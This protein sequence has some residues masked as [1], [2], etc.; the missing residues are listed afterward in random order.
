VTVA[1]GATSSAVTVSVNPENGFT[2]TVQVSLTGVPVGVTSNP[3]SPFSIAAGSGTPVIF[4]A[5]ANAVTGT[6]TVSAQGSSGSLSHSANLSLIVQP[7]IVAALPRTAFVRTDSVGLVDNPQ[8]EAR[9]RH[10]VYDAARKQLFVANRAMNRVEVLSS[11]DLARKTQIAVPAASS[12]DLSADGS[13]LWV[14]TVTNQAVAIDPQ[15]L[16]IRTRF[17][18][19]MLAPLPNTA[20]DRPEELLAMSNGSLMVRLRQAA[21]SEALLALWNPVTN[22]IANLTSVEPQ[23]FQ[24]GVGAMARS[25][26]HAKLIVGASDSSGEVAVFDANGGAVSGPR[27]LG[28]GTIPLVAADND[29]SRFAVVLIA[30]GAS[31]L[32][33]LDAALNTVAAPA[34]LPVASM[35]FSR[36]G[37]ALYVAQR[38]PS[39]AAITI[40]DGHDLHLLGQVPDAAVQG[41]PSQLEDADETFAVFGLGNRG[42]ALV[43]AS[44]PSNLPATAPAFASVPA[45]QPAEGPSAGGTA[46]TLAGQNFSALT[47]LNFGTQ[48]ATNASLAGGSQIQANS[49]ANVASGPVNL[50]AYFSNGW[51]AVA[52]EAF[53]Y[54]PQIL[55]VLPNAAAK[56]GGDSVQIYGYGFGSDASKVSVKIAGAPA[57]VQKLDSAA[58][59]GLGSDY[60]FSLERLTLTVPPGAAGNADI[61]IV[62]PSGSVSSPRALQYLQMVQSFS[63]PAFF[64]FVL[65]DQKRQRLYLSNVDHLDVFDLAA[66]QFLSPIQPPGGPPAT[67]GLRGLSLTP[68]GSQLV[69]ADFGAQSVYLIDPDKATGSIIPVGGVPG[70]TNSGPAR[71]AATS[72]QTVF[73][74]LSGEGGASGACSACLAQMNLAASPPSIQP[75]PQPEV[76]TITGTPLV[77]GNAAGDHVVVAFGT[78]PGSPIASWSAASPDQFSTAVANSSAIDVGSAADGT[79]FALQSNSVVE[80]RSPDLSLAAVP[81]LAELTQIP[82]RIFVP[83][84][85]LHPSGAL[86]YQPF[87]TGAPGAAATRGGIDI[88]DSRTGTLRLRIFL[89]Q[90]FLTDI[91]GL[92]GSFLAVD[93][94]GTRLFALTSSDGTAQNAAV[95]IVQLASVPLAIGTISPSSSPAAGGASLTIRGS[96]FQTGAS[97]TFGGK[98]ATVTFKDSNT[99]TV[100]APALSSGP[101]QILITNPDG[102]TVSLDAAFTAN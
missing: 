26:D 56:T 87:L 70:F 79:L 101:Q 36:D 71:V 2:G 102:E 27:G 39:P 6:F 94:T 15:S 45:L 11:V 35:A 59:L 90:Q 92:H 13:T 88:L 77:Q 65:Y 80:I 43:D 3:A 68:D 32:L 85:T 38:L 84:L 41:D 74:G 69:V 14:G 10:I 48:T 8:G 53:S 42:I 100:T 98:P 20:F 50:T 66:Q 52:P 58:A 1:Q 62:S 73:V 57:N 81:A 82:G 24:S 75:A 63:K 18:V 91:D 40:F 23:L 25:G 95:T 47:Q 83:G 97:V 7:G 17:T 19:P 96:G 64:K 4:G 55:Q 22:A 34:S 44:K 99:L 54:G 49:P 86:I 67:A 16:Q 31:Q 5:A 89:P 93:E 78:A 29:A 37:S 72:T 76:T 46:V 30:N 12:A 51:L 61:M 9:H 33:L 28:A 60:P 21:Q